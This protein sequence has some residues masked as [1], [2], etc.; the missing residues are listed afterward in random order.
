MALGLQVVVAL[1]QPLGEGVSGV[2]ILGLAQEVV[3]LADDVG[4][5]AL[6]AL[7][8]R[9]P[10][11]ALGVDAGVDVGEKQL[12]PVWPEQ[13]FGEEGV[14]LVENQVLA[15]VDRGRM[16]FVLVGASSVVARRVTA[17]VDTRRADHA[18][19]AA[20]TVTQHPPAQQVGP[21]HPRVPLHT[22]AVS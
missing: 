12:A 22:R 1:P 18:D 3:L 20:P 6:Q 4:D 9:F 21:L 19:H 7:S 16:P 5:L 11:V 13:S 15:H 17:V 10:L 2:G 14:E 8:L